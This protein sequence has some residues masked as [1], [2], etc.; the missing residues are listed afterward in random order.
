MS[1]KPLWVAT[2]ESKVLENCE[3]DNDGSEF[4]YVDAF[5]VTDYPDDLLTQAKTTLK[6]MGL[7]FTALLKLDTFKANE[8]RF[9]REG[10]IFFELIQEA[11][12]NAKN[13]EQL[14]FGP[15]T[16]SRFYSEN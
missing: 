15:F 6:Q 5:L 9:S 12:E 1:S 3:L 10:P 11:A 13:C 2:I 8:A 16:S 4:Q 14:T 7:E